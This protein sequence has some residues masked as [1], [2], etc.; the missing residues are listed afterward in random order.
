MKR[1]LSFA[2]L[3]LPLPVLPEEVVVSEKPCSQVEVS[4]DGRIAAISTADSII[5]F[6]LE[7]LGMFFELP[8]DDAEPPT[9]LAVSN[10]SRTVA[11]GTASGGVRLLRLPSGDDRGVIRAADGAAVT[12]L[13][14]NEEGAMLAVGSSRGEATVW[15]SRNSAARARFTD[16]GG[17]VADIEF[18]SGEPALLVLAAGGTLRRASLTDFHAPQLD[19]TETTGTISFTYAPKPSLFMRAAADGTVRIGGVSSPETSTALPLPKVPGTRLAAGAD[20]AWMALLPPGGGATYVRMATGKRT[21]VEGVR[22]AAISSQ[23][24]Y[25][26]E[27]GDFGARLRRPEGMVPKTRIEIEEVQGPI[28]PVPPDSHDHDHSQPGHQ[29]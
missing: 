7:S 15:L 6:D 22:D 25:I 5:A 17:P 24:G 1:L 19:P 20:A 21:Q 8:L 27:V 29:H 18:M 26:V 2:L 9:C 12:A 23:Y 13:R 3:L 4:A 16:L 11:W 10:Q 14:F 28:P